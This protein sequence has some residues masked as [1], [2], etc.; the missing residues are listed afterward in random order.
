MR[1]REFIAVL[2]GGIAWPV[3]ARAQQPER[4]ATIGYL[5]LNSPSVGRGAFEAGL[6]DL[7]YVEGRNIHV[8]Y[9][10]SEEDAGA[11]PRL[12]AD[13]VDQRVDVIVTYATGVFAAQRLTKTIPIVMAA[14]T[15]VVA[16]GTV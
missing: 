10:F 2:G 14:A 16:M 11:P 7:G 13:L 12:A 3:V 8:E 15:D 9:R 4:L 5:G 6:R 1:R